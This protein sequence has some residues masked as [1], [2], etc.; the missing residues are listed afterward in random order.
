MNHMLF[1]VH[2]LFIH[3]RQLSLGL[4]VTADTTCLNL[5][6]EIIKLW[7]TSWFTLNKNKNYQSEMISE[8]AKFTLYLKKCSLNFLK[9]SCKMIFNSFFVRQ[10]DL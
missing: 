1:C 5:E 6:Y 2:Y 8:I 9:N 4:G 10:N 3:E 7:L